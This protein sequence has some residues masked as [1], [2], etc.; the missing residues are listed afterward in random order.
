MNSVVAVT[1]ASGFVGAALC[2]ELNARGFAVRGT[3]RSLHSSFSAPGVKPVEV[4]HL[5]AAT[6]WSSALA[7]VDY[8]IHCA[9]RAHVM[10][11]TEADAL[12]AYR[13]VNV[14]G[15]RRLAE[16]A[17]A[18]GVRRLVCLSSIKVNGEQTALGAPFLFSDSPAPEDSYGVSKWEAE[19]V[20]WAVAA[21]TGL[22]V[23]VVRPP[24]VYGL[25]A[26]GNLERLLKLV[27]PGLPLPLGMVLNQ[28]SLIGLDNL[29]DLLICCVEHPAAAGQTLLVSDGEDVSTPDLLRHMA[30]GF[31]RSV[32]LL[33]VPLPLLRLAGRALGKQA[34]VDRLVGSL[35]IDSRHT[36]ELLNWSPPVS[37]AEG[38]QRMVQGS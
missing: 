20:L 4:G 38:I 16:Q 6:D 26:K 9:A 23:V 3:V 17:A 12:A 37:V 32:C 2:G 28:R 7:G 24:L 18:A 14:D 25:G 36:R 11:E 33:P 29:V 5:D 34:E 35:Q 27:R 10:H 8:V 19:Q 21:N 15:S 1:G 30:A 31:G 13:S 22:E